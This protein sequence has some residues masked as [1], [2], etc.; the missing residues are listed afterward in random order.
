MVTRSMGKE[1]D[2]VAGRIEPPDEA[3]QSGLLDQFS[4]AY[5]MAKTVVK[6]T[7]GGIQ[8]AMGGNGVAMEY[9]DKKLKSELYNMKSKEIAAMQLIIIVHLDLIPYI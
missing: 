2:K 1:V 3:D 5:N 8:E 4:S 7:M 9:L 6:K